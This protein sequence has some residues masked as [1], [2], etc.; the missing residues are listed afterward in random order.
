M[1]K[2]FQVL[3]IG[4]TTIKGALLE[5]DS[6]GEFRIVDGPWQAEDPDWDN[7]EDWVARE[8]PLREGIERLGVSSAG[9]LDANLGIIKLWPVAGWQDRPLQDN[10]QRAYGVPVHLLNDGE[11]HLS[12]HLDIYPTPQITIAFGTAIAFG[13]ANEHGEI[14][15]PRTDRNFDIGEWQIPTSAEKTSVWW[16]LGSQGFED[17][18]EEEG[19]TNALRHWGYRMGRFLV[20]VACVFQPRSIV[21]SG[22]RIDDDWDRVEPALRAAVTRTKPEWLDTPVIVNSP[23]GWQSA[24]FGMAKHVARLEGGQLSRVAS[25]TLP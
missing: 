2:Q 16:A 10:L 13:W 17:L 20:S 23:Y 24:L 19:E 9:F 25:G 6:S 3:D 5:P 18:Q 22:G 7:F 21:I 11:A 1:P 15:R 14:M 8:M 4:G 12:A